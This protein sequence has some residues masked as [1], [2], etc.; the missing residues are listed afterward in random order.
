[1]VIAG[2]QE[3]R[4]VEGQNF[5][6]VCLGKSGSAQILLPFHRV[7]DLQGQR[8]TSNKPVLYPCFIPDFQGIE[9]EVT[10]ECNVC[11]QPLREAPLLT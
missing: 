11:C 3:S 1:M 6:V 4:A 10:I 2:V 7:E 5:Q 9:T 8:W